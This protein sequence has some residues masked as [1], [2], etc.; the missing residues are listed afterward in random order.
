MTVGKTKE[1]K[2]QLL[3]NTWPGDGSQSVLRHPA[4][5]L[6]PCCLMTIGRFKLKVFGAIIR[7]GKK[8]VTTGTT[9]G[10]TNFLSAALILANGPAK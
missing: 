2:W 8:R 10:R 1:G 7:G 3:P 6:K 9:K 4:D 5:P